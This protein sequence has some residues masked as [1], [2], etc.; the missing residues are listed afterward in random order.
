MPLNKMESLEVP[1]DIE[2]AVRRGDPDLV[3]R[4]CRE[5]ASSEG[6]L[7]PLFA[8]CAYR[9]ARL[10]RYDDAVSLMD[11]SLRRDETPAGLRFARIRFLVEAGYEGCS[12]PAD[13]AA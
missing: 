11:E 2:E 12:S 9:A 4:L 8:K 13:H 6:E 7:A 3:A 10:N 5:H 1:D